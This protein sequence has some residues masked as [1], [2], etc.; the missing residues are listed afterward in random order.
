MIDVKDSI[1]K[2]KNF[3]IDMYSDEKISQLMLEEVDISDDKKFWLITLGFNIKKPIINLMDTIS[4][5]QEKIRVYKIIKID[6]LSGD[7][8]SMKIR[9]P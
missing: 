4:G 6:S 7:V 5:N 9:N 1:K 8:I 2:A 3:I